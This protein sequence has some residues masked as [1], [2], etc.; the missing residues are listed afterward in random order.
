MAYIPNYINKLI[1]FGANNYSLIL[2]DSKGIMP[3]VRIEK[4]F[5]LYKHPNQD[6][7]F[8][9]QEAEKDIAIYTQIYLDEQVEE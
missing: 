9:Q 5:C 1:Q 2:T 7:T 8:L 6:S 4:R 3:E